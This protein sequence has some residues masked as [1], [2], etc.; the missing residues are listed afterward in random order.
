MT[1]VLTL[2]FT[3]LASGQAPPPATPTVPPADVAPTPPPDYAYAAD[4]R[5]DP[6]VTLVNRGLESGTPSAGERSR[7]PGVA[8]LLIDEVVIR[9]FLQSRDEHMAMVS[10]P[11]GRTYS[12]RP[13]DRLFDGNVRAITP[14]AVVFMQDVEDPLS[15]EKQR[16]I[17]KS[18]RGE[19]K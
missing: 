9:G 10:V 1:M 13:G 4:G 17:R 2:L 3:A 12:I 5:R 16:E 6:F 18:L 19:V 8:G 15:L 7:P 14:E 11:G